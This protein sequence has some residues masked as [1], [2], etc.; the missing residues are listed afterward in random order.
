MARRIEREFV[1]NS[2]FKKEIFGLD[3][4]R[5]KAEKGGDRKERMDRYLRE[6]ASVAPQPPVDFTVDFN[7][8]LIFIKQT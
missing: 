5:A 8:A 1:A 7:G 4:K 6:S 3:R 2:R